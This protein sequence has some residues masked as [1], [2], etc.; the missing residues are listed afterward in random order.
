[1][2]YEQHALLVRATPT[3][4]PGLAELNTRLRNG[5]R[6]TEV[7]PMGGTGLDVDGEAPAP[8]LAAL[9]VL[10]RSEAERAA[11]EALEETQDEPEEIVEEIM[12][13]DGAGTDLPPDAP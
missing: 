10:E 2:A 4:T 8:F 3:G 11:V 1:M 9:V 12:E 7:T 13:G 6:V 5:W